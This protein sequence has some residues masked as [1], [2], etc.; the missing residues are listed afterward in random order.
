MR[1][2]SAVQTRQ[3]VVAQPLTNGRTRRERMMIVL[4][5]TVLAADVLRWVVPHIR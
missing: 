5:V 2:A 4:L 3:I 1:A